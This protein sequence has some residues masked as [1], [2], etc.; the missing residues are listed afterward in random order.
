MFRRADAAVIHAAGA[1]L[2]ELSGTRKL[3]LEDAGARIWEL[4]EYPI[5]L[6]ALAA[7]LAAEYSGDPAKITHDVQSLLEQLQTRGLLETMEPEDGSI[8]AQQRRYLGLLKRALV[9]LI[10]PEYELRLKFL[11][12]KAAGEVESGQT[13]SS[14]AQPGLEQERFLRDIRYRQP[15]IFAGLVAARKDGAALWEGKF[16]RPAHTMIGL[17]GL[18]NLERCAEQIFSDGIKGDFLEAGVCF[19]GA[20]IFMRALQVAFG[21]GSRQLWAADSFQG[22]PPPEAPSDVEHRMDLTEA[23]QPWVCCSLEGVRDNFIRYNLLDD[24][25]RFLAGW[26][27]DTLAQAPIE[28]LALLRIDADLYQST[29]EVLTALY[30]KV[31]PGGFVIVDDY[32]AII[33][34]RQ[35]VDEFRQ[36]RGITEP[37]RWVDRHRIFWRKAA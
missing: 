15:E 24:G 36:R 17:T 5:S 6:D 22:L 35:A 9:N 12:K 25:V 23:R 16:P 26:F 21:E 10:C 34:C 2:V 37:L 4:L 1:L 31:S 28:C 13:E 14:S 20:A 29:H 19:G 7:R 33:P 3:R 8:G 11:Q 18:D 27:K 32:G 30:D